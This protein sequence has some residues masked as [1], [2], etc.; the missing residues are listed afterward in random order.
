VDYPAPFLTND[1]QD[2]SHPQHSKF[3]LE[4]ALSLEF[5]GDVSHFKQISSQNKNHLLCLRYHESLKEGH[6]ASVNTQVP[7]S[8]LQLIP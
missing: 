5:F 2:L 6:R 3:T 8:C 4:S 1:C 7:L